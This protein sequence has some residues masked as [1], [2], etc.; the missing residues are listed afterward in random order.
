MA[1]I[2]FLV[3]RVKSK[4][5]KDVLK[6]LSE[7]A[8]SISARETQDVE[9][10]LGSIKIEELKNLLRA[11]AEK[12]E[13]I[14]ELS[15]KEARITRENA[16]NQAIAQTTQ[17][18]AHD[19]R[20]PFTL[21]SA[22]I[23]M[24]SNSQSPSEASRILAESIPEMA[25]SLESVNGMIQDIMEV[26][27]EENNLVTEPF[28]VSQLISEVLKN[29]FRF[30]DKSEI[31][32]VYELNHRNAV[33]ADKSKIRR[34]FTNIIGNAAEMMSGKGTIWFKSRQDNQQCEIVI[35]NSGTFIEPSDIEQLF[36]AF[37]TK[38][39]KGGTGLGLAIVRKIVEAHG[40]S[41][42]CRSSRE[43]G[44]EFILTL[45][46]ADVEDCLQAEKRIENSR[47]YH[48]SNE[49]SVSNESHSKP[50]E[51][52]EKS[53]IEES[54]S[55][56]SKLGRS[57]NIAIVDDEPVYRN[58]VKSHL[59]ADIQPWFTWNLSE[60]DSSEGLLLHLFDNDVD[61]I[62][63]DIDLGESHISGLDSIPI[64]K[65]SA[66][67]AK[68]CVH[69]N[70]GL[71]FQS[72][73]IEAGADLFLPKP[74]SRH[75]FLSVL[76]AYARE[77]IRQQTISKNNGS[78]FPG[79]VIL[80]EDSEIL[81][82]TWRKSFSEDEKFEAFTNF[83]SFLAEI[84]KSSFSEDIHFLVTDYYLNENKTGIDVALTIKRLGLNIPV[85]LSTSKEDLR[86][87]E[88]SYFS[89]ILPKNPKKAID[90]LRRKMNNR[91]E[92]GI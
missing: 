34:V 46:S 13:L 68:V 15:K 17:M 5:E 16:K 20:K 62:I 42:N 45:P 57:L 40:G 9:H 41:I 53:K 61:V 64:I 38:G 8:N 86:E 71:E 44:T 37:F 59:G 55:L 54:L 27:S 11:F 19:V 90:E 67:S 50:A 73:A 77:H 10:L 24:I 4:I 29:Q 35:G 89:D 21:F 3:L 32:I 7:V 82:N 1:V 22:V 58:H 70:R 76:V 31:D 78:K 60:F 80:V 39:K 47:S 30:D 83:D 88:V 56:L 25:S 49:K 33:I 84:G 72:K 52:S 48:H 2:V 81:V 14:K 43:D 51:S 91:V 79:K 18:L 87:D 75:H 85:F 92:H 74:I 6:P 36:D 69:S 66:P 63:L 12:I 65:E 23:D 26:G 28:P